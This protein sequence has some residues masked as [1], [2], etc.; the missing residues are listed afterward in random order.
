[1][2]KRTKVEFSV[3]RTI[4][5]YEYEPY[6]MTFNSTLT[7]EDGVFDSDISEEA[8]NLSKMIDEHLNKKIE[9]EQAASESKK[10]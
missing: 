8:T 2:T 6:V 10:T 3:S 4:Q 9:E 1:M 5:L 7:N